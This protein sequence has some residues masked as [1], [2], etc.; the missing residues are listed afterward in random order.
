MCWPGQPPPPPPS[1]PHWAGFSNPLAPNSADDAASAV[2]L[3][4]LYQGL[5]VGIGP[6]GAM[7]GRCMKPPVAGRREAGKM[8]MRTLLAQV[9]QTSSTVRRGVDSLLLAK[10]NRKKLLW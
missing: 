4:R 3:E 2:R 8:V 9:N 6:G 10:A 5:H 7:I 1:L